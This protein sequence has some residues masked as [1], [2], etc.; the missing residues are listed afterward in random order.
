MQTESSLRGEQ[1][2]PP[3]VYQALTAFDD[4]LVEALANA[5]IRLVCAAWLLAQPTD[6]RM[7]F[8]QQLEELER[9]GASPSPLLSP[10]AA[11][12]LIRQGKRGAGAITH[13]WLS[14]GDP[15]PAGRRMQVVR[16]AIKARPHIKGLFFE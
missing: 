12:A 9:S 16:R 3:D 1:A 2:L 6:F 5:V 4:R 13:G 15:D 14:P 8:R 7:P 10:A 11:V